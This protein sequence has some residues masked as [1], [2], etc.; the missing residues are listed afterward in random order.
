MQTVVPFLLGF[1]LLSGCVQASEILSGRVAKDDPAIQY[2]SSLEPIQ[3]GATTQE[4]VQNVFESPTDTQ[5]TSENGGRHDFWAYAVADPPIRPSQYVPLF[6]VL[7]LPRYPAPP[8][9]SVNFSSKGMVEGI[10]WRTVQAYSDARY[11]L[12]KFTPGTEIPIYGTLNPMVHNR[13]KLQDA[14]PRN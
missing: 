9:F 7:A 6:G 8:S 14:L 5:T 11:D 13:G 12:I 1:I 2:P 10:S 4:E 3:I